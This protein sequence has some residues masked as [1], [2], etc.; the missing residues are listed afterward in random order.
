MTGS[1]ALILLSLHQKHQLIMLCYSYTL[2]P[3]QA[4]IPKV[5]YVNEIHSKDKDV[6]FEPR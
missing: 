5:M 4:V 3:T 1:V 2:K 6:D